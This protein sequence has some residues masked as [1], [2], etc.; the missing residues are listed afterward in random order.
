P[1]AAAASIGADARARSLGRCRPGRGQRRPRRRLARAWGIRRGR[2]AALPT[3]WPGGARE[4]TPLSL[5][6]AVAGA[7][8][9]RVPPAGAAAGA[10]LA[11]AGALACRLV[12]AWPGLSRGDPGRTHC[13]GAL[14]GLVA[15][16][17]G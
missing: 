11:G 9:A 5:A 15:A 16:G 17:G 2:V 12:A 14:A 10:G 8:A 7:G 3:W 6:G 13:L 4:R 1:G